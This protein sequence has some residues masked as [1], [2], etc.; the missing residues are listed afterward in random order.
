MFSRGGSE[1]WMRVVIDV[2][3]IMTAF[4][5]TNDPF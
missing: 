3:Q 4:P 5:Q 2:E 1:R